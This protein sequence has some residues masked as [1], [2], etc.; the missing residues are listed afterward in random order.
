MMPSA[1][2]SVQIE[3]YRNLEE[4][5]QLVPEWEKLLAAYPPATVFSSWEW[6]SS[7]WQ[8][9]AADQQLLVLAFRTPDSQL[10][11]I[12]PL[13]IGRKKV[14]PG[15][16]VR[17][18]R[19]MG[20]GSGDSDNLDLL[21][22][23]GF[24]QIVARALLNQLRRQ[25]TS[26]DICQLNTLPPN[27]SLAGGLFT[28]AAQHGWVGFEYRRAASAIHLPATWDEYLQKLSSE[29]QKNLTRYRRR[30]EKR[31]QVNIYRC[32]QESELPR[33]LDAMFRL[34]Q[35]RWQG[36]GE[37][38][39]F[40][41]EARRNF[42]YQLSRE[43]LSRRSL[44]LWVLELNGEI[45][46]AQYAFRF[47]HSVFQLQ[48][49]N[50]PAR[51]SDRVGFILRG[52]VLKE[53]IGEGVRVYDFLGGEPGYKAR[54]GAT[55]SHYRDLHFAPRFS[56]GGAVLWCT[57]NAASAK[58]W[59]RVHLPSPA[60]TTLHKLNLA[61]RRQ[62]SGQHDRAASAQPGPSKDLSSDNP[63]GGAEESRY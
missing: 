28:L 56:Y 16:L 55:L 62:P 23:P 51:S 31:Y 46:S 47:N 18:L 48:E 21:V 27:S 14:A 43:L 32:S 53:L 49:G 60:W 44:E 3:T 19:L 59:L 61:L 63:N 24:E 6:L 38:G 54:W 12:A 7:W 39:S 20:D 58:K 8:N 35:A 22:R 42:Y 11:G 10:I 25:K 5:R 29:D 41:S 4:L 36:A 33:V 17:V 40:G 50:D 30:L 9:F 2:D 1:V 34:H 26:W 52:H 13:A 45:T 15:V 37:L 57:H